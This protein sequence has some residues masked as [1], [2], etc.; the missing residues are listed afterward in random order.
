MNDGIDLVR[1]QHL[2]D[3]RLVSDIADDEWQAVRYR[4]AETGGKVVD[5]DH[6]LAGIA[7]FHNPMAADIAGSAGNKHTHVISHSQLL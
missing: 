7:Q 3:Q 2:V 1:F 6:F 4:S 5:D